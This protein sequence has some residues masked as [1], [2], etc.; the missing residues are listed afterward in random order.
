[1]AGKESAYR[2]TR[3]QMA[4]D[5]LFPSLTPEER[6]RGLTPEERLRALVQEDILRLL[7]P[8]TQEK[9]KQLVNDLDGKQ[10]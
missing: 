7:D 3:E 1:M 9:L 4:R 5:Y 10:T 6:L 2:K 8:E